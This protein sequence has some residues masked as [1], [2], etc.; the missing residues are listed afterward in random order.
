MP[1]AARWAQEPAIIRVK[2]GLVVALAGLWCGQAGAAT[3]ASTAHPLLDLAREL[4]DKRDQ[5]AHLSADTSEVRV[6]EHALTQAKPPAGDKCAGSMGAARYAALYT[7]LGYASYALGDVAGAESAYRS[8]LACRPRDAT[9]FEA[10]G[11]V[12]FRARDYDGA[13]SALES[14][15]ALDPRSVQISRQLGNIDFVT[16]R[17]AD[18]VAHYRYS[19]SSDVDRYVASYNQLML[20][21]AQMRAGIA[22]P[23]FVARSP[24][25][26]WP[27][28]LLLYLRGQYT[29]AELV[30]PI[31]EGDS[32]YD[33][34]PH[35]STEQRLCEAL[36]YVGE[37]YL[38]RGETPVAKHYFA[39]LVNIKVLDYDEHG[40]ALSEIANLQAR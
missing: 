34:Q 5:P 17:W 24:R 40:L 4:A 9:I 22:K 27:Q 37:T 11:Q 15:L 16:Q 3:G 23:E 21:L 30:K 26:G 25:T 31:R 38:A 39:A 18:A 33:A 1:L 7:Q 32:D 20:W 8:A 28:P 36:F 2:L 13:R 19:A 29:E 35:T 10:I 14:A 6:T 12:R